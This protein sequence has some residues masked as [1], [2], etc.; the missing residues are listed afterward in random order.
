MHGFRSSRE[1]QQF[2]LHEAG[3]A[4]L[5]QHCFG[6]R[7]ADEDQ[8]YIRLSYV[9]S[10]NDIKEALRRIKTALSDKK[11]IERFLEKERA[12]DVVKH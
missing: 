6:T 10:S 5:G 9:S 2:L 3:V 1:L 12:G 4:V 11:L 7:P 8:E